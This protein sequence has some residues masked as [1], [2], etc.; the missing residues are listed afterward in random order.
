MVQKMINDIK[1]DVPDME[2]I[3]SFNTQSNALKA[4]LVISVLIIC[5]PLMAQDATPGIT[6]SNTPLHLIQPDYPVPYKI[7][8]TGE[9]EKCLLRIHEYLEAVTPS[10]LVDSKTGEVLNNRKSL[11][12]N[13]VFESGDFRLISYEWG[14]TYGGM[15]LAGEVTG[16]SRF[17]EYAWDRLR[18]ITDLATFYR[19][20]LQQK[21]DMATP[22]QSVLFPRALDD[23]GAMCAAFIKAKQSGFDAE[24]MPLI[25]NYITYISER[26]YR[27]EDGTLAR[28]RPRPNT[29]WI[30]DLFMSVPAL[31]Q[32]GKLTGQ[33]RYFDDAVRQVLRFSE[34][35]FNEEKGLY[36]HGWVQDMKIHPS[37]YWGRANGWALMAKV[38][39][40]D[41]LPEDHPGYAAVLNLLN[42]HIKGLAACQSGL[43]SWHQLLDRNDSYLETSSTAIFVYSFARSIN[44]GWI[45]GFAYGPIALHG[46]NAL[47]T[48]VNAKGQVEGT[49][50]GTGMGFDLAFYYFRPVNVYAAHG[51]GPMLLAGSEMINLLE[52]SNFKLIENSIQLTK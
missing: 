11:N 32:M 50:V 41:V 21:R 46:W 9:I 19:A 4:M 15:L 25:D 13:T 12:E 14:V 6:D 23:A 8:Q 49:C 45:D 1:K 44:R 36:M 52:R 22:V 28:N 20:Q 10:R 38:E 47:E 26:Q 7:P 34:R 16:D 39:L 17:K 29:L 42:A 18:L 31:A 30:D 24:I 5:H 3:N 35:M 43:G 40:L 2:E 27:L 37:Y 33:T 48:K 51:Y